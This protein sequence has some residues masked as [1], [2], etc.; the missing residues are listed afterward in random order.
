VVNIFDGE[1][2]VANEKSNHMRIVVD[3]DETKEKRHRL[4]IDP[5]KP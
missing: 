1:M 5:R 3:L 4:T 2:S